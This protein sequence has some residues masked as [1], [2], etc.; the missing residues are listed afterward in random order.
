[1]FRLDARSLRK[2]ARHGDG[3]AFL[4]LLELHSD[5]G[6]PRCVGAL[7][8]GDAWRTELLEFEG[9][10]EVAQHASWCEP[11]G[12]SREHSKRGGIGAVLRDGEAPSQPGAASDDQASQP[13]LGTLQ[14]RLHDSFWS[15]L[16]QALQRSAEDGAPIHRLHLCGHGLLQQLPLGL[17]DVQDCPGLELMAWPGLPYLRLAATTPA[18]ATSHSSSQPW[19]VGHDCAWGTQSTPLPMVAVEAALLRQ[20]LHEHGQGV[21]PIARATE[22][23]GASSG[24]VLCCHGARAQSHFDSSLA[25]GDQALSVGR[26]VEQRLGPPLALLPACHAGE[27]REDSAGNALGVAAGFLLGGTRVVV[28]SSK[29]VPDVLMPWL[30]TLIVWHVM[31]GLPTHEAAQVGRQQFAAMAFPQAY[32]AWLQ[33]ALLQALATIQPGGVEFERARGAD[34]AALDAVVELW[35]WQGEVDGLFDADPGKRQAATRSIAEGVLIPREQ[36]AG[37]LPNYMREMAA[38]VFVYGVD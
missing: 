16:Q 14:Q 1:M 33:Q 36:F 20:L 19:L 28:A 21:Q 25:L 2:A 38:F 32:R 27:T 24:V 4:C 10:H 9:L 37:V 15:V 8:H 11:F 35:P 17:R 3:A 7:V 13:L 18:K 29:A 30:S 23:H 6:K 26:I 34:Y 31:Q 12:N 5:T 22:V